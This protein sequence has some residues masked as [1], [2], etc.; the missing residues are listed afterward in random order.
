MAYLLLADACGPAPPSPT[1]LVVV[2]ICGVTGLCAGALS[3]APSVEVESGSPPEV[4]LVIPVASLLLIPALV[5]VIR[6]PTGPCWFTEEKGGSCAD[7][8]AMLVGVV[9][10]WSRATSHVE[11]FR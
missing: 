5:A 6:E 4:V 7:E 11:A 2:E 8:A 1:E 9:W 10:V 3:D